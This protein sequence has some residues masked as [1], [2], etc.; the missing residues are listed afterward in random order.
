LC[1]RSSRLYLICLMPSIYLTLHSLD[2]PSHQIL[3]HHFIPI[4]LH[5]LYFSLAF[6]L[7]YSCFFL[8]PYRKLKDGVT[9]ADEH[10]KRC[11]RK[12]QRAV[13]EEVVRG[14]RQVLQSLCVKGA[15]QESKIYFK[16]VK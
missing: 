9:C 12:N 1:D 10:M 2:S 8:L 6:L 14:T 11:T 4:L 5:L 3:S 7:L 16:R 15:F 13:F